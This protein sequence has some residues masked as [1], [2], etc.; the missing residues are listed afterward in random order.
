MPNLQP[1]RALRYAPSA[2]DPAALISPPYDV[3][4]PEQQARLLARDPHNSIR[5]DLPQELPGDP[6]G[7]R[8]RRAA[9]TLARW[10]EEGT[11]Q[12]D[13]RP[14][15]YVYE[16]AYRDPQGGAA[17]VQ[18]GVFVELALEPFG[19]G[20]GVL[21]HERT[22]GGP[23]ADRLALLR[24]TG[25]NLSP[26][27]GLF[28]SAGGATA[29]LLDD[30]TDGAPTSEAC[31]D[32]RVR[33]RLWVADTEAAAAT[34]A[35]RAW[36]AAARSGPITIADGHHRYETALA[37]RA[38]RP[39]A[40]RVLMLL[41]DVAATELTILPTHR[42]VRGGPAGEALLAAA[43]ELFEVERLTSPDELVARFSD[44][45]ARQRLGLFSAGRGAILYPR[46]D[47]LA[48]RLAGTASEALRWLDV[49]VLAA[50]LEA[51]LGI[52]AEATAAG[53]VAYTKDPLEAIAAVNGGKA[54]SA[55]LLDPTP[56]D[57]VLA[58]AA[59]GELMPQKSTYFYPKPATGLV[60]ALPGA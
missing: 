6:P 15:L 60:F 23:K 35:T 40:D 38:E 25:A 59:A 31:D 44:G 29:A 22:M 28:R 4:S 7:A 52:D 53:V 14:S 54:D 18:R 27:V 48:D 3:I 24:A 42:L 50:A 1:F 19:P 36:L 39:E 57:A 10:R 55:F 34:A 51:F 2:G 33:H 49:N 17:R 58:V 41:F 12:R 13:P 9:E 16:L 8:Y 26:V 46:R 5:L 56:A 43:A 11:L 47:A 30:L 20:G 37:Y 21:P 45:P 32:D